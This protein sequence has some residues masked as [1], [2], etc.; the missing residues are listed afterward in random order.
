MDLECLQKIAELETAHLPASLAEIKLLAIIAERL[1][2]I[3]AL[4]AAQHPPQQPMRAAL[5]KK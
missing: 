2:R 4:L 5:K 1:V 3:E